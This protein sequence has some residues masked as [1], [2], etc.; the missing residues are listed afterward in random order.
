MKTLRYCCSE[1]D[2]GRILKN[3][4]R[5][6]LHLSR[7]MTGSLKYTGG[8][9]VNGI[10]AHTDCRLK[11]GDV[12][13]V[14]LSDDVESKVLPVKGEVHIV[15][16]DDDILI[17]DKQAPLATMAGHT[18]PCDSLEARML[19]HFG[20][21]F[22]FRPVNRLDKGTS[23]LMALAKHS[24][25]QQLMQGYLHSDDYIR[26]YTAVVEGVPQ[27]PCGTVDAPIA[28]GDGV[29]RE[30]SPDGR[31]AVT[32]Y[33]TLK[34]QNGY[35]LVHLRLD[36]GR[37][38]QIRVHMSYLGCPIAGDYVYGKENSLLPGRFALHS[39]RLV[40]RHPMTGERLEFNSGIPAE[41]ERIMKNE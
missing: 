24:H 29:K 3:I 10:A 19:Y 37:T 35:S 41:F 21:G 6:E 30:V 7:S 18:Q 23:G 13:S 1:K 5:S 38:H 26:E 25:A 20:D 27:P 39:S 40:L 14:N 32:H 33:E 28:E 9:L 2:E 17:V 11:N 4:L 36:T 12:V 22:S 8:I 15:Y 16:E 31:R 34:T